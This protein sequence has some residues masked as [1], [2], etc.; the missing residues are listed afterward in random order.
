MPR[1]M[2]P[3]RLVKALLLVLTEFLLG[4]DQ[5]IKLFAFSFQ[6]RGMDQ[7]AFQWFDY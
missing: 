7:S 5:T 3:I 1:R 6:Q 4:A 2:L